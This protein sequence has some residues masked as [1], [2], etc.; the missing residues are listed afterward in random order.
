ME[1]AVNRNDVIDFVRRVF[2]TICNKT[3]QVMNKQK[4]KKRKKSSENKRDEFHLS[5]IHQRMNAMA[6]TQS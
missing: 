6:P 3:S 4:K 2:Y 5:N 1:T